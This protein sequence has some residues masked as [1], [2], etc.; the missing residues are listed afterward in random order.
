MYSCNVKFSPPYLSNPLP[1][2]LK[3]TV[4]VVMS[5]LNLIRTFSK[6]NDDIAYVPSFISQA[7]F[8]DTSVFVVLLKSPIKRKKLA[9]VFD[10][11]SVR[12][13]IF[14]NL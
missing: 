10:L 13:A 3:L 12:S 11:T 8:I 9:D 2:R 7:N 14:R 6:G 5:S 1:F 4:G